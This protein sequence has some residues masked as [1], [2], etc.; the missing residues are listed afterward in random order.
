[1]VMMLSTM[2]RHVDGDGCRDG[3]CVGTVVLVV[4]GG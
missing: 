3:D 4:G 2:M 1:M